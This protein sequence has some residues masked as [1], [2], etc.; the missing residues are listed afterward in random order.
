LPPM[1]LASP[2][3]S[4]LSRCGCSRSLGMGFRLSSIPELP[5]GPI[6]KYRTT[7]SWICHPTIAASE[8]RIGFATYYYSIIICCLQTTHPISLLSYPEASHTWCITG[9]W[10]HCANTTFP[11][12]RGI[13]MCHGSHILIPDSESSCIYALCTVTQHRAKGSEE[14]RRPP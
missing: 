6:P 4:I 1:I 9:K 3:V 5:L 11:S 2:P 7:D 10:R 13:G 12:K 14:S 8:E